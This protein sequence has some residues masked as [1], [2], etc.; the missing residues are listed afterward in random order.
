MRCEGVRSG[1]GSGV[2]TV[3]I[4]LC[5]FPVSLSELALRSCVL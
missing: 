1:G 4:V 2:A 5:T 3:W